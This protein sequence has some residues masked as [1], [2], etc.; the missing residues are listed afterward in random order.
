MLHHIKAIYFILIYK[1]YL[2]R[3]A[4][5]FDKSNNKSFIIFF[6]IIYYFSGSLKVIEFHIIPCL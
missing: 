5:T 2:G 6:V 3:V 4:Y 1:Y